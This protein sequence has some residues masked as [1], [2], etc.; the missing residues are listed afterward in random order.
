M[1]STITSTTENKIIGSLGKSPFIDDIEPTTFEIKEQFYDTHT[2][3]KLKK[4]YKSREKLLKTIIKLY[5]YIFK[6]PA[7]P[8]WEKT[9]DEL[10]SLDTG[11]T[12]NLQSIIKESYDQIH[13]IEG[14]EKIIQ[15]KTEF[16]P[17]MLDFCYIYYIHYFDDNAPFHK[18]PTTV[19]KYNLIVN[20]LRANGNPLYDEINKTFKKILESNLFTQ[21]RMETPPFYLRTHLSPGQIEDD[22]QEIIKPVCK[23]LMDNLLKLK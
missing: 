11:F 10:S 23:K 19:F 6:K 1:T 15:T 5:K 20:T 21:M 7:K 4:M 3:Y 8:L 9:K 12:L 22:I 2:A 13:T 14:S 17:V 16:L 18:L